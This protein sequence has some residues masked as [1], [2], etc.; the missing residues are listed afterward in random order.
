MNKKKSYTNSTKVLIIEILGKS[1]PVTLNQV[2]SQ[3]KQNKHVTY[4]AVHKAIKELVDEKIV[5]KIDKQYILNKGWVEQQ[6]MQY[7]EAYSNYFN[8]AYTPNQVNRYSKVQIFRFNSVKEIIDFFSEVYLKNYLTTDDSACIYI[9]LKRLYPIVS[10][11]FV[12]I[13]KKMLKTHKMYIV[14]KNDSLGDR[15]TA[16]YYRTLGIKVK[17]GVDVPHQNSIC[18]GDC[19]LQYF[20]FFSDSYAKKMYEFSDNFNKKSASTILKMTSTALY[21]KTEMYLVLNKYP[22]FVNDIKKCITKEFKTLTK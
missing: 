13:I 2:F 16:R 1:F 12:N 3:L 8:V 4:Q 18:V 6:A 10:L 20:V 19:L 11:P 9:S 5:E 7:S 17:T 21:T 15:W 22:V 14:C